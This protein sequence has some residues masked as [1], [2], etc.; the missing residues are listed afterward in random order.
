TEVSRDGDRTLKQRSIIGRLTGRSIADEL[1]IHGQCL[2]LTDDGVL[3]LQRL[4]HGRQE[5]RI[6]AGEALLALRS[7]VDLEPRLEGNRVHGGAAA[8]PADGVA[9]AWTAAC[10]CVSRLIEDA[11]GPAEGMNRVACAECAP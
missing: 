6:D 10:E 5:D 4:L 3:L 1:H 11:H 9:R 2:V 7:H 8:D